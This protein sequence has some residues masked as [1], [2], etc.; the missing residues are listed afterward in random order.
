[1]KTIQVACGI[2]VNGDKTLVVQRNENMT[3]PLKWE[4]AGGKIEKNESAEDCILR[5]IKEELNI[6]I[7]LICKMTTNNHSYDSINIELIP[8]LANYTGGQIKLLEHKKYKWLKKSELKSLNWAD[9]DIPILNEY[10][11]L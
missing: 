5:E 3:L 10:L 1:M 11:S 6:E 4:F 7:K 2:I 9:A 8:F